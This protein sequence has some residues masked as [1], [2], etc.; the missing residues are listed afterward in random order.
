M[1]PEEAADL[2]VGYMRAREEIARSEAYE[3]A[4]KLILNNTPDD[5][6][7]ACLFRAQR[8]AKRA[9]AHSGIDLDAFLRQH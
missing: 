7:E 5:A 2:L 4:A 8:A 9:T 1:T 6:R 3:D